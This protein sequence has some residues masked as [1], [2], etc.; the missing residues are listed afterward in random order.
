MESVGDIICKFSGLA[1]DS[2]HN[3]FKQ[4]FNRTQYH[5]IKKRCLMMRIKHSGIG[6]LSY[7][8]NVGSI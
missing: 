4:H 3:L 5:I 1:A 6:S 7:F 8:N 2:L